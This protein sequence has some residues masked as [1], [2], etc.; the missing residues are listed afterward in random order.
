MYVCLPIMGQI[1][2]IQSAYDIFYEL[3]LSVG[4]SGYFGP[5]ALV[6]V[7]YF[8]AKKD[9]F[10]SV[11]WFIVECLVVSQYLALVSATPDYWWHIIIILFGG[12]FTLVYPL[13][14]R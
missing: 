2:M 7:G 3:F 11:L 14:D 4:I 10:L 9:R 5:M 8:V 1:I 12:L 6:L 13:W